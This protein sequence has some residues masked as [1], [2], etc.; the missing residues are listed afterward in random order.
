[1]SME[2]EGIVVAIVVASL[3]SAAFFLGLMY[4]F[5]RLWIRG[6]MKGSDNKRR[7]DGRVVV[8]TGKLEPIKL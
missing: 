8:I 4:Y 1:M 6:P 7:L 3:I 5:L 2:N